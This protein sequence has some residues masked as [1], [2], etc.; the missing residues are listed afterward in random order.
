MAK[1]ERLGLAGACTNLLPDGTVCGKPGAGMAGHFACD[2]CFARLSQQVMEFD[3]TPRRANLQIPK[4]YMSATFATLVPHGDDENQKKITKAVRIGSRFL[5]A[6]P[7][8][9]TNDAFP[10]VLVLRGGN[11]TGKTHWM[12]ALASAM[13]D[14]HDATVSITDASDLVREI[15]ARWGGQKEGASEAE[16]LARYRK[17][18]LLIINELSRHAIFGEPTQHLLEI[19]NPRLEAERPTVIVT[20]ETSDGSLAKLLGPALNSRVRGYNGIID[21]GVVDYRITVL[22][23]RRRGTRPTE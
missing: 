12:W 22:A 21:F 11:G 1:P 5:T 4:A 14:V 18:D 17:V 6:Y 3:D 23:E 8:R 16:V 2:E 13:V 9:E 20:N 19:I 10:M 7:A 15:R